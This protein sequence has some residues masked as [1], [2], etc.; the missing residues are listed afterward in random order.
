MR[1][2]FPSGGALSSIRKS[3][4]DG[5]VKNPEWAT[6]LMCAPVILMPSNSDV[7]KRRNISCWL[8]FQ[9]DPDALRILLYLYILFSL[10][11]AHSLVD[12]VQK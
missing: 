8:T 11:K 7:G 2:T 1:A 12:F 5:K 9:F 3:L 10:S 4:A 6:G